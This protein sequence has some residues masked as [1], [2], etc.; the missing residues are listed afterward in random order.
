LIDGIYGCDEPNEI[1]KK[2]PTFTFK[3][4]LP[5]DALLKVLKWMFIEQDLT[6]W[7]WSG[8]RMLM[9]GIRGLD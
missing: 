8:R 6:Y 3:V 1:L 7:N 9:G 4:G 2:Y 5:V